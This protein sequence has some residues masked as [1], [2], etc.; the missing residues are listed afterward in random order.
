LRSVT[1]LF[2]RVELRA[3]LSPGT[4]AM[5]A[6]GVVAA[7]LFAWF[8]AVNSETVYGD[9]GVGQAIE[10]LTAAG[11]L[12]L[13]LL[14]LLVFDR[15][16]G[17]PSWARRAGFVLVPVGGIA[18]FFATDYPGNRLCRLTIVA[19]PLLIGAYILAGRMK[20]LQA[21]RVQAAIL[22]PVAAL[23]WYCI[24]LFAS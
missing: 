19:I 3:R 22:L 8:L 2:C 6:F 23:S 12:W 18:A 17:G 5:A 13:V 21:G 15:A 24:A 9:A 20:P 1:A 11:L 7:L 16:L 14:V 4:I 10:A